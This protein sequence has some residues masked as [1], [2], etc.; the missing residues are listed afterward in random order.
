MPRSRLVDLVEFASPLASA[1]WLSGRH[2]RS[3]RR[4]QPFTSTSW[5][6]ITMRPAVRDR[7]ER[8]LDELFAQVRC[9]GRSYHRRT[10]HRA[11]QEALVARSNERR[12][13]RSPRTHQASARSPRYLESW[14]IC[15]LARL[16]RADRNATLRDFNLERIF[17]SA[18]RIL[19][20][21]LFFSPVAEASACE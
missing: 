12:R 14:K 2:V 11:R 10:R 13:A 17:R 4:R 18:D 9:L 19:I 15:W 3:C 1:P 21:R 5:P 20:V 7:V 6:Q 16:I 8:A